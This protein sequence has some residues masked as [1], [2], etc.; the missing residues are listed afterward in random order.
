MVKAPG[1]LA[2]YFR[3]HGDA[4]A[5]G[6]VIDAITPTKATSAARAE[7]DAALRAEPVSDPALQPGSWRAMWA[8]SRKRATRDRT[9][10]TLQANR[11]KAVIASEKAS[12]THPGGTSRAAEAVAPHFPTI[13]RDQH[14]RALRPHAPPSA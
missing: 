2:S 10:L 12:V 13:D 6:Q 11:A 7:N 1:D 5:D 14:P 3:W 9:T 4:F 8:Y